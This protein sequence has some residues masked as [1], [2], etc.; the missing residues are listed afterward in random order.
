M[1]AYAK[2]ARDYGH[3]EVDFVTIG[4]R[5]SKPGTAEF[6]KSIEEF[7]P[8]TYLDID[9]QKRYLDRFPELWQ[10]LKFDSIQRRNIG[11]LMAYENGADVVITI[12]DDNFVMNQDFVGAHS[13]VGQKP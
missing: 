1:T 9:E 8:S 4:D 6:C 12:D 2:N 13:V 10:H 3:R 11:I 7:Y 5:K